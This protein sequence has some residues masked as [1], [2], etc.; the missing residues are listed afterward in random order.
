MGI[1]PRASPASHDT[2]GGWQSRG[3]QIAL[4]VEPGSRVRGAVNLLRGSVVLTRSH[5]LDLPVRGTSLPYPKM[6]IHVLCM[7][8]YAPSCAVFPKT[9][10]RLSPLIW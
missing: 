3:V 1:H 6:P 8:L 7:R 5:D 10:P 9:S 2:I 4:S